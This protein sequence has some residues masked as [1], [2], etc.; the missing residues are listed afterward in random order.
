LPEG[1]PAFTRRRR[2][3][4]YRSRQDAVLKPCDEPFVFPASQA[5]AID[6]DY[7]NLSVELGIEARASW[8]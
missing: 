8:F 4:S 5:Y 6:W 1:W 7:E 2:Y 3:A